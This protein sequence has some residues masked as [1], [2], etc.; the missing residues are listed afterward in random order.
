MG[1]LL[2]LVASL[3]IVPTASAAGPID[4]LVIQGDDGGATLAA[5]IAAAPNVNSVDVIGYGSNPSLAQL[6]LYDVVAI[7]TN[8]PVP[9]GA[10]LGNVL[11]DYVDGGGIV[12]GLA[13]Y[14]YVS[15]PFAITGRFRTDGYAPLAPGTLTNNFTSLGAFDATH[16]LMQGVTSLT[17][18]FRSISTVQPGATLVASWSDG[19]PAVAAKGRVV[20]ISGYAGISG[21]W[22]G[23]YGRIIANAADVEAPPPPSGSGTVYH[24]LSVDK[25]GPG[26]GVVSGGQI[27]C[28]TVC[29]AM[30]AQSTLV[31]LTANPDDSSIFLGWSGACEGTEPTCTIHMN[32]ARDVVAEF[33]RRA[34][35][36]IVTK[37]GEGEGTVTG[38]GIACGDDCAEDVQPGT[39]V[40][41]TAAPAA[42]SDFAG[43]SGACT[44]MGSCTL[45]V[46]GAKDVTATFVP[47]PPQDQL[48]TSLIRAS[49]A[50]GVFRGSV[51]AEADDLATQAG[52]E[53]D[54]SV[55]IKKVRPGRDRTVASTRTDDGGDWSTEKAD[56][57]SGAYYAKV[58][59]KVM[60]NDD[61]SKTI[62]RP[63]RS[64]RMR[65]G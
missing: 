6:Q 51:S 40:T 35:S 37:A 49:Y 65:V 12:V 22:S 16:P 5:Q 57:R 56:Y 42:G 23:D 10:G 9:D 13:F 36:V 64:E 34:H 15:D 53:A 19:S 55:V 43:W 45:T 54:R 58:R 26:D 31:T 14:N 50:R 46:D 61:G 8:T 59:R 27:N 38:P 11:A 28:G 62:C 21:G 48:V 32:G 7:Y 17:T 41:L 25:T 63:D 24:R 30:L 3:A 29:D 1:L 39:V 20:E 44:G 4:V 52:C 60:T 33:G 18:S 2:A 47:E